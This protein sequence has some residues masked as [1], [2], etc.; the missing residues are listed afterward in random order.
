MCLKSLLS[1]FL[2][3]HLFQISSLSV[4]SNCKSE[5]WQTDLPLSV[6]W[7]FSALDLDKT[8]TEFFRIQNRGIPFGKSELPFF[9]DRRYFWFGEELG[10]LGSRS[11]ADII[12]VLKA[13]STKKHPAN[14]PFSVAP[15]IFWCILLVVNPFTTQHNNDLF[16]LEM[17][18]I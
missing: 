17:C 4:F 2:D 10:G 16:V 13:I 12:R 1:V 14:T 5:Q 15:R 3:S 18:F 8:L 6:T 9:R 11:P 7:T